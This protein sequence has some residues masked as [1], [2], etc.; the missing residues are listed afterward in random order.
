[1]IHC[2]CMTSVRARFSPHVA[3][4]RLFT[5]N[6]PPEAI[7]PIFRVLRLQRQGEEYGIL[8][9]KGLGMLKKRGAGTPFSRFLEFSASR[10]TR[11]SL[12]YPRN[13]IY[14]KFC[15]KSWMRDSL[16]GMARFFFLTFCG[17]DCRE[18]YDSDLNY[19]LGTTAQIGNGLG[20]VEENYGFGRNDDIDGM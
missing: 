13:Y 10:S 17:K 18:I 2:F 16:E 9:S 3:V 11:A 8:L 15:K 19:R 12:N 20:W 4:R 14:R 7:N 5:G 1:M 6:H